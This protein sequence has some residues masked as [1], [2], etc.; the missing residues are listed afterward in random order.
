MFKA[1]IIGATGATGSQL[2]KKLL[3]DQSCELVTTVGRRSSLSGK[4]NDK[5]RDVVIPSMSD[6]SSTEKYWLDNDV[7]FNCIG[8]TRSLAGSASN[9][10][11]IEVG[12]SNQAAAMAHKAKINHASL[13][14][15]KGANQNIWAKTWL[16]PLFYM[17]TIGQ[18]EQS[19]L[20]NFSFL[21]VSIF[22]PGMLLRLQDKQTWLENFSES[23]GS[24]L[25]VDI[26]A[27]SMIYNAVKNK[28]DPVG[29][30]TKFF[31]G[32]DEIKRSLQII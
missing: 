9:F 4:K 12:I 1:I 10:V 31:V 32:N 29:K 18:K 16:H 3:D 19:V 5:L 13:I 20:T 2:L 8:T 14:S 6:L 30:S 26:L 28:L 27:S 15:A 23:R 21:N 17:K 11:D 24:G 25:R 7:F 22:R